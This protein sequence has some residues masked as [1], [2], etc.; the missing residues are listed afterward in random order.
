M[1]NTKEE[2]L[3]A[4][5]HLFAPCAGAFLVPSGGTIDVSIPRER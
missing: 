4:S 3:L 5:L 1:G 2:I